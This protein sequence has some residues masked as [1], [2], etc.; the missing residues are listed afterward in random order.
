MA[1]V[2]E[3]RGKV[4]TIGKRLSADPAQGCLP[5]GLGKCVQE[6]VAHLFSCVPLPYL[7]WGNDPFD[8]G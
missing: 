6:F 5:I 8:M 4:H 3:C 7:E 1:V 2:S